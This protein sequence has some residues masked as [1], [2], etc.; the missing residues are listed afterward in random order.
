[1]VLALGPKNPV[2]GERGRE[3]VREGVGEEGREREG[4]GERE[5][6]RGRERARKPSSHT[7]FT[8]YRESLLLQTK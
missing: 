8:V 6:E 2:E 4:G 3:R 7:L 5:D 1:M